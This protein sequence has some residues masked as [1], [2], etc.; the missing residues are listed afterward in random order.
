LSDEKVSDQ[1]ILYLEEG[2]IHHNS[3]NERPETGELFTN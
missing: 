3:S 2:K 1:P